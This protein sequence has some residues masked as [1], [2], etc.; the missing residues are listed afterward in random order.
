MRILRFFRL[1]RSWRSFVAAFRLMRHQGVPLHLKLIACALAILI[2][3]PVN[4]LGDIPLLGI[5]DDVALLGLL[6]GWFVGIAGRYA[7]AV[8]LEGELVPS[9][10]LVRR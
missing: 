3:S 5:F 9:A 2:L 7:A 1:A 6:A 10:A 8:T 4:V